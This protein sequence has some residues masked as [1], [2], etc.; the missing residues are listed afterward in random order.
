VWHFRDI[1]GLTSS[2]AGVKVVEENHGGWFLRPREA[3]R[4]R[5]RRAENL[6]VEIADFLA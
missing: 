3:R 5:R 1:F 4:L 6:D 2:G